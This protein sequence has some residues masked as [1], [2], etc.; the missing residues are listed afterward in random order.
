MAFFLNSDDCVLLEHELNDFLR[1]SEA[2]AALLCDRG[3][4]ILVHAGSCEGI[5]VDLVSALVAGAFAATRELAA[6]LGEDEFSNIFHQGEKTSIF[7][8][9]IGDEV[10]LLAMFSDETTAGL[11]KMFAMKACRRIKGY[12]NQVMGREEVTSKDPT[13]SFVITKGPIFSESH[14]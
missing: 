11:V 5:S 1:N 13:R 3:G 8:A 12:F 2:N 14:H 6:V 7:I 9:A 10:L 4:G